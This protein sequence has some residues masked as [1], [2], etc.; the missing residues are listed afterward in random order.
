M[1]IMKGSVIFVAASLF[2]A[3][4]KSQGAGSCKYQ[5]YDYWLY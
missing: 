3:V 2:V 4:T 5:Y 1:E